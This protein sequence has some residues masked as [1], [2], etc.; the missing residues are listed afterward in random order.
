MTSPPR[1][2]ERLSRLLVRGPDSPYIRADLEEGYLRDLDRGMTPFRARRRYLVNALVSGGL[3]LV[4]GRAFGLGASW[5]DVKLAARMLLKQPALTLVAVFALAVGIPVGLL[6]QHII[7]SLMAPIP[8]PQGA[9]VLMIDN[10]NVRTSNP[11]RRPLHDFVR[12]RAE[13]TS[14]S[15]IG[16]A[17]TK[18]VNLI[19]DDGRSAPVHGAEVTASVFEILRV[20]PI[21]GRPLIIDDEVPGAPDVVVLGYDAWR[22]RLA[23][24]PEVVGK[25]VRIGGAPHTIVGVMP[26]GFQYPVRDDLWVPFRHEVSAYPEGSGPR[27]RVLARLA[28]G[29]TLEQ[30]NREIEFLGQRLATAFPETHADLQ[31]RV[32]PYAEGLVGGDP[33]DEPDIV[34]L[35]LVALLLLALAC[36]NVG[37]L[38]LARTSTRVGELA[39]R[40]ALGA[41]RTR[42]VGQLFIE[43]LLL[44]VLGAGVG[45]MVANH[46]SGR[47]G[48]LEQITEYWIDFRITGRTVMLAFILA[49]FSAVLA[50]VVPA[51]RAT[52]KHVQLNMQRSAGGAAGLRFGALSSMLVVAEVG[53]AVWFL[54]LSA[55][56]VPSAVAAPGGLGIDTDQYLFAALRFPT[57]ENPVRSFDPGSAPFSE[58]AASIQL[59][60]S[61]RVAEEPGLRPLAIGVPLPG[62]QHSTRWV[63]VEGEPPPE[64]SLGIRVRYATVDIDYFKAFEQSI[65]DGRDFTQAD[66]GDDEHVIIVNTNFADHVLRGGNP[67]GR[68]IRYTTT[69]GGGAPGPWLEIVGVVGP[70]GMNELNPA[71]DAGLYE[72]AAPGEINPVRLAI[73]VG[74]DPTSAVPRLR[75]I[76]AEVDQGAMLQDP[77]RLSDVFN[78]D[79]FLTQWIGLLFALIALIAVVLSVAGL[80][81]LMS[82][83]VSQRT[84][85]IGIRT[86]LGARPARIVSTI[87]R[88]ALMQLSAGVMLGWRPPSSCSPQD[89]TTMS[90]CSDGAHGRLS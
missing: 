21:M 26:E 81:A 1:W 32:L 85:E 63:E 87:A 84:R 33:N 39:V 27:A 74:P 57:T 90:S 68:R 31:P 64:G 25:S 19:A 24:D 88:R 36:G 6:P 14:F 30:A 73:K 52:G 48:A 12:W 17:S 42:I 78:A 72:V 46:L 44:A 50:G 56:L 38:V 61:E 4:T 89:Q 23:S 76:L 80:Y 28:E 37:I 40:T 66:L 58:R 34:M 8:V 45:L 22:A 5:L 43:S 75:E 29:V 49:V 62:M 11:V 2:L 86:A 53:V 15:S 41:S 35:R 83:T 70:L 51:L 16:I 69:L 9:E 54:S 13:L 55:G 71:N 77:S 10:V 18:P 79:R 82:F 20:K 60:F 59:A 47:F 7:G 67:I 65:L 3:M